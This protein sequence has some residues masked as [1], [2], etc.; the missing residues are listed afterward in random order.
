[1]SIMKR[2]RSIFSLRA[3]RSDQ[4]A[5]LVKGSLQGLRPGKITSQ[6]GS[7]DD[8]VNWASNLASHE[9]SGNELKNDRVALNTKC[10]NP[11]KVNERGGAAAGDLREYVGSGR[12]SGAGNLVG[13]GTNLGLSAH[14]HILLTINDDGE[15]YD[16]LGRKWSRA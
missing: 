2:L 7:C 6:V 3:R 4:Q 11:I 5:D 16:L 9:S 12:F 13:H 8:F 10:R 14:K 1:M 15:A